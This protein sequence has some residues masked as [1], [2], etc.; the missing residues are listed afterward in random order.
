MNDYIQVR[1]DFEEKNKAA[2]IFSR[3]GLDISTAVRL[4][5]KQ[6]INKNRLPF[7]IDG[8]DQSA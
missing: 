4:F 6:T 3:I 5:L 1:V 2:Q 7:S 8:D